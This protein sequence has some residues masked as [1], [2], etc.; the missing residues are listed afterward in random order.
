MPE[1]PR[2]SYRTIAADPPWPLCWRPGTIRANGRG[3]RYRALKKELG[4]ETMSIEAIAALPVAEL[5]AVDAHLYLWCPD[6]FL[7]AGDAATVARAWGFEPRRQ[8]I[9][10]K[11]GYGMGTFPRPQH[12]ALVF[13]TRGVLDPLIRDAGS[14]H[15]WK[16]PYE[17]GARK[18][19][20]KPEGAYDL[21]ERASPGPYL[22]LF[23][24]RARLGWD[25]HGDESLEHVTLAV[26]H[27]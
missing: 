12:E 23:S 18:H 27:A 21:I 1:L 15:V 9:W 4:Y 3:V 22:E 20:A 24:R 13:C 11:R 8:I 14:W 16:Q 7:L 6:E 19:S 17:N 5:A 25:H 26:Q 10:C 2:L